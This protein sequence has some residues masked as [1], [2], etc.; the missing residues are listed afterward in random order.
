MNQYKCIAEV[1]RYLDEHQ[2]EQPDLAK[3][4]DVV[5]LSQSHFHRLFT[6]W[7]G[8]TPK[9][10][11][12]YLTLSHARY[13]L[14]QGQS[15]LSA[16]I[17]SGLSGPGR[18]HDLCVKL[19]AASPGEMKSG[20][21][22]W[23]ISYGLTG[24]PFGTCLIAESPR[25]ICHL[26]F[27]ESQDGLIELDLLKASWP[28]ASYH[29]DDAAASRLSDRIFELPTQSD[30]RPVLRAFVQ[31]TAFQVQVWRALLELQAGSLV[32]YGG[33]A[34]ALGKP[35]AARSV[36]TALG[37]NSVAYLIPCHRV[38]RETGAVSHYR[39]GQQRKRI[40]LA[41]ESAVSQRA[42]LRGYDNK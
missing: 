4:A 39:W 7:A 15:V 41:W 10:F 27:V 12:Q 18:L 17:S 25:G 36:G 23:V 35:S 14:Q 42:I 37:Q 8:I 33:L 13:L 29:R 3:L 19:I 31:G 5:G 34:S 9:E 30:A 1:I 38:I 6:A 22:N 28:H 32:S 24:S 40:M 2:R 26:A 11:L 16:A 20:G 21:K